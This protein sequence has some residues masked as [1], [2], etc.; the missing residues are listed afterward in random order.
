M[1]RASQKRESIKS[2]LLFRPVVFRDDRRAA[3]RR[4]IGGMRSSVRA[5]AASEPL[6]AAGRRVRKVL[7]QFFREWPEA[8]DVLDLL[9]EQDASGP[10]ASLVEEAR[11][12]IAAELGAT[13][14]STVNVDGHQG[15]LILA[16]LC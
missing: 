11:R 2:N 3:D 6:R 14:W 10:P 5:I 4:A 7:E 9:G 12:R 8:L 15:R 16:G 1:T 13:E